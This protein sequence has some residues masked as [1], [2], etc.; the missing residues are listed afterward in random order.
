[1]DRTAS[2]IARRIRLAREGQPDALSELLEVYRNY[3]RLLA[4]TS[5]GRE[6]RAKTDPSDLVQETFLKA[7]RNF[8]QFRGTTEQEWI[9]WIRQ[10]LVRTLANLRRSFAVPGR[11]VA[12]EQ[13]L[14]RDVDRSSVRL[15]NLALA[16]G[17]SPGTEA[18][19]RELEVLVAD[20]LAVLE[21]ED[22]EVIV[23]RN[24]EELGWAE[25]AQRTGRSPDAARMHWARSLRRIGALLDEGPS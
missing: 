8:H 7:H 11:S 3:V 1:M 22:R 19:R 25:I 18:Q 6:L 23:L 12:R 13:Q 15:R 10:I 21:P 24:I 14:E 9:A 20:A 16:P 2:G 5:L 4:S 17:P